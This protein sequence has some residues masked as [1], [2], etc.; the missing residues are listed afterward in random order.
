M[1]THGATTQHGNS[2]CKTDPMQ[3]GVLAVRDRPLIPCSKPCH[4]YYQAV[5]CTCPLCMASQ[6]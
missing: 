1:R 2:L 5:W 4:N 3:L 6:A